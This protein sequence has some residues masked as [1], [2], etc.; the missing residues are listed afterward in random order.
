[1]ILR[2]LLIVAFWRLAFTGEISVCVVKTFGDFADCTTGNPTP[3]VFSGYDVDLFRFVAQQAG[4]AEVTNPATNAS[5]SGNT[6]SFRFI[7]TNVTAS[8]ILGI[9]SP[10]ADSASCAMIIGDE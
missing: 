8:Q 1:M 4:W 2:A 9:V 6:T 10:P 5:A 7:C 3:S